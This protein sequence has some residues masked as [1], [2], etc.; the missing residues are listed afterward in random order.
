M[1]M[2]LLTYYDRVYSTALKVAAWLFIVTAG[3]PDLLGAL[4]ALI[5][6]IAA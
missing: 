6:R 2:P 3:E 4:V 5:G 1:R